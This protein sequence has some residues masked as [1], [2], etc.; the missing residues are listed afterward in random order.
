M[1]LRKQFSLAR[2]WAICILP[3][4]KLEKF[5][6]TGLDGFVEFVLAVAEAFADSLLGEP[7]QGRMSTNLMSIGLQLYRP[8]G[9]GSFGDGIVVR[10]RELGIRECLPMVLSRSNNVDIRVFDN[11]PFDVVG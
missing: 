9:R 1:Y 3:W 6:V 4:Q 10:L 11:A 5:G 2:E 7:E 8:K